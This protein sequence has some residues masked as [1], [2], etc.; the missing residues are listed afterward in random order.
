LIAIHLHAPVEST[1]TGGSLSVAKGIELLVEY[2]DTVYTDTE[3]WEEL[4]ATY[5]ELGL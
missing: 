4:A 3:A 2:V 5:A 1:S